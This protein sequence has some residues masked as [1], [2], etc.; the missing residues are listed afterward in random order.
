MRTSSYCLFLLSFVA[1]NARWAQNGNTVAGGHGHGYKTNQLWNP[2]GLFVDDEHTVI[3]ADYQNHRIVEWKRGATSGTVLVGGNGGGKRSDQLNEP[4][5]VIFDKETDSLI[6]CEYGNRRVTRW[7][8]RN[9]NRS[10][11]TII[12]KI[13]CWGLAMDDEGSLYV[14]D[15]KKHEVRRY[16]RGATSG[17]VVAGGYGK[18][19]GLHQLHN[20][21]YV[22]VDGEHA[23][24][25][26]D[27]ENYRV[28]KWVKGA[29]EGIV[30]AGGR[31]QGNDLTQLG[32]PRGVLVDAAGNVYVADSW[33]N[34]VMRW[35]R[36]AT[37]GTHV[38]SAN[39]SGE[40]ATQLRGPTVLFFDRQ[41]HLYLADSNNN[42]VQCFLLEKNWIKNISLS[43]SISLN[44][45]NT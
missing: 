18:G 4:T 7:S 15:Y 1:A 24:Y 42:R 5:D 21:R 17:A 10:G 36:G 27:A 39:G 28:M 11:E 45:R 2:C 14:T 37:Q 6:I 12:D 20:P 19:A 43:L 22:C 9:G 16:H 41:G 3:V 33:N 29:K 23:V 8:R 35:R 26:S 38:V 13:D 32:L 40:G 44:R 25:V 30:V 31:G 34:R